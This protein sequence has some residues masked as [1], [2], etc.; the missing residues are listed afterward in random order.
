MTDSTK[1]KRGRKPRTMPEPILDT[2]RNLARIILNTPP[3]KAKDWRY[4]KQG[5]E[6]IFLRSLSYIIPKRKAFRIECNQINA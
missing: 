2:P 5:R 1:G 3:K 4:L 6:V